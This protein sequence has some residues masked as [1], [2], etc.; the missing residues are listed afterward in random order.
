MEQ[1]PVDHGLSQ[2]SLVRSL[3][4]CIV[5]QSFRIVIALIVACSPAVAALAQD[6]GAEAPTSPILNNASPFKGQIGN[7]VPG[8]RPT[9]PA[10][11]P[12]K[13]HA[14][15]AAA[16]AW[17]ELL[18]AGKFEES[19]KGASAL[20][21]SRVSEADWQKGMTAK[22]VPYGVAKSRIFDSVAPG[23]AIPGAPI[24]DYMTLRYSTQFEHAPA[25]VIGEVVT[26]LRDPDGTWRVT[27]YGLP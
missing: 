19:W 2:A 18:D 6:K 25:P 4:E 20:L 1:R 10:L 13:V 27:G 3:T 24:A 21:Q 17:L 15:E 9:A 23:N 22:R 14:A 12:E 16:H 8:E 5:T 7:T 26:T 11:D